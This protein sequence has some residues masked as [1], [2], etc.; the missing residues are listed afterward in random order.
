MRV[1]PEPVA[2]SADPQWTVGHTAAALFSFPFDEHLGLRF[3]R[4]DPL[5]LIAAAA[6][7]AECLFVDHEFPTH[8][9][10]TVRVGEQPGLAPGIITAEN[11]EDLGSVPDRKDSVPKFMERAAGDWRWARGAS[12]EYTLFSSPKSI[13]PRNVIQGSVGNCGFC[14]GFASV[15]AAFPEV[16][17]AAFGSSG[18]AAATEC[19]AIAVKLYPRGEERW[20]LMDDYVICRREGTGSPSLHSLLE[21]DLWIRLLEKAFVKVQSSYASLEGHYKFNSLYR[22]PARALQFLTG[23]P[24]AFEMRISPEFTDDTFAALVATEKICGRVAHCRDRRDD[25]RSNHGYSLLWVG[26]AAGV[27]LAC[28]RNPHGKGSYTGQYGH[29]HAAWSAVDQAVTTALLSLQSFAAHPATGRPRWLHGPEEEHL[30]VPGDDGVFLIAFDVFV[31][32]FPILTIVGP[33]GRATAQI[34]V[35]DSLRK[36]A[37]KDV[38]LVPEMLRLCLNE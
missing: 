2:D 3:Y 30:E 8:S 11:M 32:C 38:S 7:D 29:G 24:L 34:D 10:V 33:I 15:A 22:H 6:T 21:A 1:N 18:V 37:P 35:P 12:M 31:S 20:L 25:L 19:G 26:E 27:R 17:A 9:G 5:P 4:E 36:L 23:A 16:I 14:A 13:S 28:L